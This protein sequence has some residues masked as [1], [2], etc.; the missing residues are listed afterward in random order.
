MRKAIHPSVL[1]GAAIFLLSSFF[2]VGCNGKNKMREQIEGLENAAKGAPSDTSIRAVLQMYN[3]YEKLHPSDR[4]WNAVYQYRAAI[5]Y[6]RVGNYGHAGD[7]LEHARAAYD[8]TQC[9]PNILFLSGILY[10]EFLANPA[11]GAEFFRAFEQR[12]PDHWSIHEVGFYLRPEK[13][14]LLVRLNETR[15]LY[16]EKLREKKE[17]RRLGNFL[18]AKSMLFANKFRDDER[19]PE[20][21][22]F[23]GNTAR[24]L[25]R[26][27][28]AIQLWQ[29]VADSF[30]SSPA[31]P[32]AL[33]A[34]GF[35]CENQ[36]RDLPKA[37][38]F[39]EALLLKYPSHDMAD[40]AR[41]SL[42]NLGKSP[43]AIVD[44]FEQKRT[45]RPK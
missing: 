33:M 8:G 29:T 19:A 42:K 45:N 3:A 14:K 12:F 6:V 44:L 30:P 1:A 32:E 7:I 37:K 43:D 20:Y 4:E 10:D 13:E 15:L 41:F 34:A 22:N 23:A 5:W 24:D 26:L 36:L 18:V 28:Q 9:T 17:R 38:G 16:E 25:G 2:L 31:A 40:D 11:K 39:Y 35:T 27:D 21:L